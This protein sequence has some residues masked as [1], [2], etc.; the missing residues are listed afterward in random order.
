[1]PTNIPYVDESWTPIPGCGRNC[2]GCWAALVAATKLA[3]HPKYKGLAVKVVGGAKWTGESRL[4]R[5]ALADPLKWRKPKRIAVNLMGD[6][7]N[8]RFE[9][10]AAGFGIMAATPG[11][12]YFV[13]TKSA[14]EMREWFG[15]LCDDAAALKHG[16]A[17]EQDILH[18]AVKHVMGYDNPLRPAVN[19]F[20]WPLPNV[21]LGISASTQADL[22]A[23]LPDL[24]ACPAA[25]YWIS[26]E[27][28]AERI[29]IPAHAFD[30]R[31]FVVIGAESG[32]HRRPFE[33]DWLASVVAQCR[34]AG[35]KVWT[36]QDSGPR[37]GMRGRIPD[38]LWIQEVP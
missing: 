32:P 18:E 25:K 35:V 24:L 13:L 12:D 22:D 7:F 5:P 26:L 31:P 33:I 17:R 23:R 4:Y 36:K 21:R 34:A 20:Q 37:P 19:L 29:V 28:L 2:P 16:R 14:K 3:D 1:M 15:W 6:L 11:H 30:L 38:E 9:D 10:I 27:P 8:A